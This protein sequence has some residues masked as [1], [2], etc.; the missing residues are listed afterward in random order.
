L[1]ERVGV[2][3]TISAPDSAADILGQSVEWIV[4][5]PSDGSSLFPFSDFGTIA[6]SNIAAGTSTG[7][8]LNL[9]CA[10]TTL[11]DI[12]TVSGNTITGVE[13]SETILC[14]TSVEISY[15]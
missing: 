8:S 10:N 3:G 5:D 9:G 15:V 4:E 12:I 1:S 2:E 13:S 6:F 14:D 7:A 11:L